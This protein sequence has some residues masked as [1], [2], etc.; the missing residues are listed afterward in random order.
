M[1]IKRKIVFRIR[2]IGEKRDSFQI[3]M[4]VSFLS[5]RFDVKTGY[6]LSDKEY[7]DDMAE[8]VKD[9]YIGPRGDSTLSINNSLRNLKDQ[10]NTSF[11]YFEAI[12]LIPTPTEIQKKYEER[13]KGV[14]PQRP[15]KDSRKKERTN[16]PRFFE[17]FDMFINECSERNAWSTA[18]VK[19]MASL[20]A[21]LLAFKK[22]IHFSD[23]TENTL[24][25][26][27]A[28]LR[29]EK[30]IRTPRKKKGEREE[31]AREDITGLKNSTIE[32]KLENLRWFLKWATDRGYNTNMAFKSFHPT[33][34]KTQKRIIFLTKDEL[35]RVRELK[36]PEERLSLDPVRDVFLFCCYSGLRHSDVYNL[37]R[38]DVKNGCI[39]V[40]TVKTA[41]SITIELNKRTREILEKY[42]SI[43]FPG[44]KALP[45]MQ[46]QPMNRA[47]KELCRLAGIDEEIR[48][49]TYKGNERHDEVHPK[50]ELIGTHTGRRT[51]IVNALSMGIPPNIVM[52]WTGH[53]DYKAMKPYIDI[54]D[55]I[56]ASSMTKFDGLI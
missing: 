45:V 2:P 31:Y 7:W 30:E 43:D 21:D 34:K 53:S 51:F 26:F 55:S 13:M 16:E 47:L 41:D 35:Q 50:W 1:D 10:M 19:K 4:R 24:T 37:R 29:D 27:V 52:K 46:N 36:L 33:L 11:K 54:V 49:T 12:D 48:V 44:N 22:N 32:K 17:V 3:R 6:T 18:T 5:Q 14:V 42:E 28:Y 39:E 8:L 20:R 9:G 25:Q 38:T 15:L 23:L 40:T 56:K